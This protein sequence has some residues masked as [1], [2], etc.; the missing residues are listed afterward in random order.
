ME[1][2]RRAREHRADRVITT[3]VIPDPHSQ[4]PVLLSSSS[5]RRDINSS[6]LYSRLRGSGYLRGLRMTD[7]EVCKELDAC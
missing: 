7:S 3:P 1:G 6:A 5:P 2:P 4:E